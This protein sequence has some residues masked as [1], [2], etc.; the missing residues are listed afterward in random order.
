ML[1]G[2]AALL[3]LLVAGAALGAVVLLGVLGMQVVGLLGQV[4][5][6]GLIEMARKLLLQALGAFFELSTLREGQA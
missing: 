2:L 5:L 1:L 3:L 6:A 4:D